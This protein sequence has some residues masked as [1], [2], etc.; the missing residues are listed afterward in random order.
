MSK[1]LNENCVI[2][3]IRKYIMMILVYFS[4]NKIVIINIDVDNDINNQ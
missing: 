2:S 3:M 4:V 1:K